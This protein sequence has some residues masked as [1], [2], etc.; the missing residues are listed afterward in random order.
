MEIPFTPILN[1]QLHVTINKE[2]EVEGEE[3]K[4]KTA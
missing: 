3:K 4:E 1:M 2:E